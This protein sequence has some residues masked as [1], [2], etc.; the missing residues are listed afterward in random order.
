MD[1]DSGEIGRAS[2]QAIGRG[3]FVLD[4]QIA[5]SDLCPFRRRAGPRFLDHDVAC[6]EFLRQGSRGGKGESERQGEKRMSHCL[7]FVAVG[8]EGAG[9]GFTMNS[10]VPWV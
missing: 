10:K 4:R 3:A 7:S 1:F 6:L 5:A 2:S 8:L 9:H